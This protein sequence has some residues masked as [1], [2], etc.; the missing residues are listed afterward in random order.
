MDYCTQTN[1]HV[2]TPA[3]NNPS[4]YKEHM[5]FV[6]Q[7]GVH[8]QRS[9]QPCILHTH[10]H[11]PAHTHMHTHICPHV[12]MH[13]HMHTCTLIYT[14]NCTFAKLARQ[15]FLGCFLPRAC[16]TQRAKAGAILSQGAFTFA[17]MSSGMEGRGSIPK[18]PS[19][20][21]F[22]THLEL[23]SSCLPML[24]VLRRSKQLT[25]LRPSRD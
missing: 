15:S 23:A 18:A 16:S 17:L 13:T 5:H 9:S 12:H 14:Q 19:F 20:C 10:T 25:I 11:T 22:H 4:K 24:K 1:F 6:D 7:G 21:T 3:L 2:C 8:M